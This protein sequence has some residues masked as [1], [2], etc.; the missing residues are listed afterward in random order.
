MFFQPIVLDENGFHVNTFSDSNFPM[1]WHSDLEILYCKRGRYYIE[2]EE[3]RHEINNGDII[4]IGSCE[5]H[6]VTSEGSA[7][8]CIISPGFLFFGEDF[9]DIRN[10]HFKDP[11]LRKNEA[12]KEEIEK[13][14]LLSTGTKN[15]ATK[16]ELRGRICMLI[17]LLLKELSPAGK[18]TKGQQERLFAVSKIQKAL[19]FVAMHYSENI[20][21]KQAAEISG[22]EKSAFCRSFK[23][24]TSETFHSYLNTYRIKK[25]RI[26]LTESDE[27]ISAIACRV[28]F[29]QHKNFC[30]IF[31]EIN[32]VSPSDYR[33]KYR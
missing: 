31:K 3:S 1:H 29:S 22:Y 32:G 13:V 20:T 23:N 5:P 10:L 4:L 7:E 19:D 15:L 6:A 11:V 9:D 26:L 27:S 28:G 25:A 18:V 12:I 30:R 24:A 2:N 33:K 8:A 21:V 14:I 17:S 16:I